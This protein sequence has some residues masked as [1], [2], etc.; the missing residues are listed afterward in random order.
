MQVN[1]GNGQRDS[2]QARIE[3]WIARY[4]DALLRSCYVWLKDAQLAE[5]AMQDTFLKAWQAME[6]FEQRGPASEKAWLMRIAINTCRDYLRGG[7]FQHVDRA[8]P[9]EELPPR[10]L[11]VTDEDRSTFLTIMD[12]PLKH[13]HI[14]LLYYYHG[15]TLR[16]CAEALRVH[17]TTARHRLHQAEKALK[18]KLEGGIPCEA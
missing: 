9:L 4:G 15:L 14:I 5:D 12:L 16:E 11:G 6:R 17:H 7:W 13:R 2:R 1:D 8:T 18:A 10:L 3:I